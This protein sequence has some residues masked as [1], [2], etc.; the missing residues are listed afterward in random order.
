VIVYK[1]KIAIKNRSSAGRMWL[2]SIILATWDAEIGRITVHGQ[3]RDIVQEISFSENNQSRN[4]LE[5]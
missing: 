3:P 2:T 1:K 5:M 4:E